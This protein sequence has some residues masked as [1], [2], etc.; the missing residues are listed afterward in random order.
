MRRTGW[1]I[2]I[3]MIISVLTGLVLPGLTFLYQ[4][5]KSSQQ[6]EEYEAQN[7]ALPFEDEV[8]DSLL[9]MQI[10]YKEVDITGGS[11]RTET[12]IREIT[13]KLLECWRDEYNIVLIEDTEDT[14]GYD[15]SCSLAIST[16]VNS[17]EELYSAIIWEVTVWNPY[18][19]SR[20]EF[21]FDD[22]SGK[23]V[24]FEWYF[25]PLTGSAGRHY[26]EESMYMLLE[27]GLEDFF[28]K[29]YELNSVISNL[30]GEDRP[31]YS[32]FGFLFEEEK[33]GEI[34]IPAQLPGNAFSFNPPHVSENDYI[35]GL[36]E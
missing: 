30:R 34:W 26:A 20:V 4:D 11:I 14:G 32:E 36:D 1:G 28:C 27:N 9:L 18:D 22:A 6:A 25:P 24:S 21:W 33:Y 3:F 19:E 15:V 12:E 13:R 31:E 29:Y 10:G 35:S 2:C 5:Q 23:M 17:E 8:I 7:A 16:E